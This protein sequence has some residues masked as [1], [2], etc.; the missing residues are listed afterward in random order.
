MGQA[1]RLYA[2][3]NLEPATNGYCRRFGQLDGSD[4]IGNSPNQSVRLSR[5]RPI[6]TRSVY[7]HEPIS[8]YVR[9]KENPRSVMAPDKWWEMVIGYYLLL[10]ASLSLQQSPAIAHDFMPRTGAV[11]FIGGGF[12]VVLPDASLPIRATSTRNGWLECESPESQM[13][14]HESQVVPVADSAAYYTRLIQ[15][16]PRAGLY[17]LRGIAYREAP[18]SSR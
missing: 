3:L 18:S 15:E 11:A 1:S 9:R 5:T 16:R 17:V 6:R 10:L 2:S 7:L 14:I 8:I 12:A 13:M 4:R